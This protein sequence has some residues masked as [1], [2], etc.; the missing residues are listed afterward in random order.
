M[1]MCYGFLQVAGLTWII[2]NPKFAPASPPAILVAL[3]FACALGCIVGMLVFMVRFFISSREDRRRTQAGLP[4]DP[5]DVG[6]D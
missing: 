2:T 6:T 4:L 3:C 5:V 1:L